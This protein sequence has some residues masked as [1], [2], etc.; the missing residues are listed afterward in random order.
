LTDDEETTVILEVSVTGH[1]KGFSIFLLTT[2]SAF[3][4]TT[5]PAL[6]T[7]GDVIIFVLYLMPEWRGVSVV[8]RNIYLILGRWPFKYT[9]LIFLRIL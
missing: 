2:F 3:S 1:T 8:S 4:E 6:L 9:T 5:S 7:H